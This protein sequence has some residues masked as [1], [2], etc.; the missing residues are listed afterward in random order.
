MRRLLASSV[1]LLVAAQTPRAQ[2]AACA[3]AIVGATVIDGNGGPPL[4]DAAV[5]VRGTRIEAVGTRSSVRVPDCARRIDGAGTFVTPG[6]VDTNVHI[7]LGGSMESNVRYQGRT[8]HDVPI[9]AP[10]ALRGRS[11]PILISSRVFQHEI[12]KQI[13]HDLG[14][15]NE[16]I[17]LYEV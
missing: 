8:L 3:I 1:L 11:E 12:T 16:I 13:R 5:L 10:E 14:L 15:E 6:F 17:T 7:S 9:V 2:P 4:A